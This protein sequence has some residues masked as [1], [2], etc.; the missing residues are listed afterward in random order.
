MNLPTSSTEYLLDPLKDKYLAFSKNK[1]LLYRDVDLSVWDDILY[2]F[3]LEN[4]YTFFK[5]LGKARWLKPPTLARYH[6]NHVHELFFN[7]RS[8]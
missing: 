8:W 7:R 1:I 4:F 2:T 6:S 5:L 3:C